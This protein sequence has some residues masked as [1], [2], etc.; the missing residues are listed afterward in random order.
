MIRWRVVN[1]MGEQSLNS[2]PIKELACIHTGGHNKDW[3]HTATKKI[4]VVIAV[5]AQLSL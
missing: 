5:R 1:N 4:V 3:C 2:A